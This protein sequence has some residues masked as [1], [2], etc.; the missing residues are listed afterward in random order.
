[1][2]RWYWRD[3]K[4]VGRLKRSCARCGNLFT[5][6]GKKFKYCADCSTSNRFKGYYILEDKEKKVEVVEA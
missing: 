6:P 1:M 5:P 2:S 3:D 4:L